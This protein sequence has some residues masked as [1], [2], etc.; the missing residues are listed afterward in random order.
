MLWNCRMQQTIHIHMPICQCLALHPALQ[1]RQCRMLCLRSEFTW[2][3]TPSKL[4]KMDSH[5]F[6]LQPP[7][8]SSSI[9][10]IMCYV[11]VNVILG[12]L[13]H[14]GNMSKHL[15]IKFH[16]SWRLNDSVSCAKSTATWTWAVRP[17]TL[18]TIAVQFLAN[19]AT[20]IEVWH[21]QYL[22]DPGCSC[23]EGN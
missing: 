23:D 16:Q 1:C 22:H 7:T 20:H 5:H 10:V 12:D 17:H 13:Q 11:I 9:C 4:H 6:W 3:Q 2:S 14:V 8:K 15:N 21:M 19:L 18:C